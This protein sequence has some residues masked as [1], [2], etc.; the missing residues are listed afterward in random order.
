ML[1]IMKLIIINNSQIQ[2]LRMTIHHSSFLNLYHPNKKQIST[3]QI[4]QQSP[5]P[6]IS[7]YNNSA[8]GTFFLFAQTA[9]NSVDFCNTRRTKLRTRRKPLLNERLLLRPKDVARKMHRCSI[10]TRVLCLRQLQS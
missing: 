4:P 6:S 2:I 9:K 7:D 1:K 3:I 5:P 10:T 8:V